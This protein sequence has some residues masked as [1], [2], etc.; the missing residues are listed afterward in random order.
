MHEFD[1]F[2]PFKRLASPVSFTMDLDSDDRLSPDWLKS[3][4]EML[5][6]EGR[7]IVP[8]IWLA[9]RPDLHIV[10]WSV[11]SISNGKQWMALHP[12]LEQFG[13]RTAERQRIVNTEKLLARATAAE[14]N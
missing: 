2:E 14:I 1:V 6:D 9:E 5:E 8:A 12:Y 11:K 3:F 13:I 10:D 4:K 7:K